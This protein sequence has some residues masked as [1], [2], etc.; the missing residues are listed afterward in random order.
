MN[1][2]KLIITLIENWPAKVLALALALVLFVFNQMRTVT[3]RHLSV[4]LIIDT[5]TELVPAGPYPQNV[6]VHLRGEDDGIRAIADGDIEAFVD[7]TRY[8]IEGLYHVPVQIR[9]KGSALGVEPLEISVSPLEVSLY[10]DRRVEKTLLLTAETHGSVAS[11]FDLVSYSIVPSEIVVSGPSGILEYLMEFKTDS[12]NLSGRNSDFAVMVNIINPSPFITLRESG[13]AV[14]HGSISPSVPVRTIEGIP[15]M[16]TGLDP[17]FIAET[18]GRTGSV[19]LEGKAGQEQLDAFIPAA[20]FLSVDC[21]G[22]T[23]PGT[24][25]LPIT[26]NLP[27]GFDLLRLEPEQL[28]I[29]II[30]IEEDD[31]EA[32]VILPEEQTEDF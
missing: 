8:D 28:I 10:L 4:P 12:V 23:G 22:L 13:M 14:F 24:Y 25:T 3:T 20:D 2:R 19:R 9:K 31:D 17:G 32:E 18:Q 7:F 30:I 6:R 26:I 29:T 1:S 15:F 5:N 21:S 16:L 11:G 27:E